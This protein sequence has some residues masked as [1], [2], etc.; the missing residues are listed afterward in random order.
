MVNRFAGKQSQNSGAAEQTSGSKAAGG[1]R[2]GG[3]AS[4][5]KSLGL[6]EYD[7]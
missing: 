5:D 3:E 2:G 4:R 1:G 7:I 6:I